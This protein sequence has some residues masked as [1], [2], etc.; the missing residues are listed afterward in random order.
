VLLAAIGVL[1]PMLT[2]HRLSRFWET[3][4][5]GYGPG[6]M[7]MDRTEEAERLAALSTAMRTQMRRLTQGVE[8]SIGLSLLS[9]ALVAIGYVIEKI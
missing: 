4:T 7:V 6:G 3:V 2:T 8:W 5:R 9:L 1:A